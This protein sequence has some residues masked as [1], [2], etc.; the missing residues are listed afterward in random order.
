ML[1][2][3]VLWDNYDKKEKE[4]IINYFKSFLDLEIYQNNWLW[5]KIF[6]YLFLEK[7][8]D[9]D[10]S[11]ETNNR[12]TSYLNILFLA[13]VGARILLFPGML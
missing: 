8:N 3:N 2:K 12:S 4:L 7:F 11:T 6:H 5:F 13:K 9:V 1:T 10:Y